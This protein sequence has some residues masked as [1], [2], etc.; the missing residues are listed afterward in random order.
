MEFDK[1]V[2]WGFFDGATK[3]NYCGGGA[4]LFLLETH[5]FELVV[6]L[7]EGS[8][9]FAELMSLKLLLIFAA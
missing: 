6:G 4:L 3:N 7:G 8:N 1:S 9:N 2:P 5:L